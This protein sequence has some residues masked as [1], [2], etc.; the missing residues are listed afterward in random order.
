ME[1]IP[2]GQFQRLR[3]ICD[4]DINNLARDM[5][6]HFKQREYKKKEWLIR[7]WIKWQ[8]QWDDKLKKKKKKTEARRTAQHD[9]ILRWTSTVS[10]EIQCL[11]NRNWGI[12]QSDP[13]LCEFFKNLQLWATERLPRSRIKLW[14]VICLL[15]NG[16]YGWSEEYKGCSSVDTAI[17]VTKNFKLNHL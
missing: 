3:R 7:L 14:E 5:T 9:H 10:D 2:L 12:I 11:T 15:W 17:I 4:Q 1:S 16:Q 6:D 13:S 8:L